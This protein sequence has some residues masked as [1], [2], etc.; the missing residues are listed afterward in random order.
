MMIEIKTYNGAFLIKDAFM[1]LMQKVSACF[2]PPLSNSVDLGAY[3]EKLYNYA[4]F[5]TAEENGEIIA[6]TAF[7]RNNEACQLYIP[8]ICV[9]PSSQSRGIGGKMLKQLTELSAEGYHCIALE[10]RKT[11]ISAYQFYSKH[12]FIEKED[13]GEKFLMVRT[14]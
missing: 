5:V 2:T 12:G 7:Y 3:S 6:L 1:S 8:L 13:R 9:D 10:V 4:S 14:I 11:N